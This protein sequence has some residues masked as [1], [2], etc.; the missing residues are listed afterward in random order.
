M[1]RIKIKQDEMT[2]RKIKVWRFFWVIFAFLVVYFL[3]VFV[4]GVKNDWQPEEKMS[5]SIDGTGR[6]EPI[7]DSVLSFMTWNVGYGSL[8][9]QSD[10][11]FDDEG[12]WYASRSMVYSDYATCR[13]YIDGAKGFIAEHPTDFVLIQEMDRQSERSYQ[14]KQYDEYSSLLGGDATTFAANY[15]V[16]RVPIPLLQ[17][18][19]AYGQ[20]ESGLATWSKFR[21]FEATRYQLPGNYPLPDRI[22][23]LD[24]CL[25]VHRFK[26]QKGPELVVINLH[27][28]AYD[29]G[30]KIKKLQMPYLVNLAKVEY[31]KG[32]YVILGGD[33]NQR[34]PYCKPDQFMQAEEGRE[35][36]SN[37][38]D[39]LFPEGWTF[40]FDISFPT[41]RKTKDPYISGQTY[42]TLIDFYVVSP[43]VMVRKVQTYDLGF[44]FS[45]HQP[46]EM[47]VVLK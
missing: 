14:I 12:M 8:G 46:V 38:P 31:E 45:D 17:P 4:F 6:S 9:A 25:A 26:T 10:F 39:D 27:N 33:W 41:N 22:F 15:R 21:P 24:R 40:G 47:S 13:D 3:G 30:D 32:N 43:N 16:K 37:I 34:P 11:F 29:P 20:V 2:A 1:T 28:S 23:Q 42:T 19:K 7:Q 44:A 5:L 35:V 18:W 36:E